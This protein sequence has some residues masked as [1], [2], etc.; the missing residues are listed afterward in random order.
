M[1]DTEKQTAEQ[2][3]ETLNEQEEVLEDLVAEEEQLEEG[4]EAAADITAVIAALEAEKADMKDQMLRTMAEM[5]NLRARTKR[6]KEDAARYAPQKLVVDLLEVMD[7]LQRAV[8]SVPA[9]AVAESEQLKTLLDGVTMTSRSMI[10]AFEKHGIKEVEA[11][12]LRLDPHQHEAL[13]EVPDPNTPEGTVVQVMQPGFKLH[14]RL[15]RPARVGIAKGGPSQ[16]A[17]E[18]VDTSA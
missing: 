13:F 12:G 2:E 10:Q 11:L 4:G 16:P 8:Q 7:N 14:D 17:P 15:L 5:E 9:D 18:K 1:S 6:E 3:N